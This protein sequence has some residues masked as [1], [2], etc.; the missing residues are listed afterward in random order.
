MFPFAGVFDN[1][2]YGR[3]FAGQVRVVQRLAESFRPFSGEVEFNGKIFSEAV[4]AGAVVKFYLC[5]AMVFVAP[6]L[7]ILFFFM[8]MLCLAWG[9]DQ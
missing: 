3:P 9:G 7:L 4:D 5:L 8:Q 6:G 2:D 1:E